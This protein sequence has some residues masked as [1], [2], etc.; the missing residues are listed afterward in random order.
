VV[1]CEA[2]RQ[3]VSPGSPDVVRAMEVIHEQSF[4]GEPSELEDGRL[5]YFHR[6]HLPGEPGHF[7]PVD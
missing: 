3:E 6:H 5:V 7:R 4:G 1:I 2:C